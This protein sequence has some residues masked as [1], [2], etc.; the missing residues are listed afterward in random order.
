MKARLTGLM[1]FSE[2]ELHAAIRIARSLSGMAYAG[3]G[4]A[5]FNLDD[6]LV[7]S[8][9]VVWQQTQTVLP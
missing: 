3:E 8:G 1:R 5:R 4:V 6:C 2:Q 9:V 7:V